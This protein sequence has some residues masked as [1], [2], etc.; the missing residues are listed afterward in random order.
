MDMLRHDHVTDDDRVMALA[1]LLH[2]F[3]AE[4]ARLGR[5]KKGPPRVAT[6]GDEVKVSR[7]IVAVKIPRHRDGV[8]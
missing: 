5:A 1:G 6:G 8:T 4:M 3:E 2:D 7:A